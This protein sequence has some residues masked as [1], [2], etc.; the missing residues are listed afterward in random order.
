MQ[1]KSAERVSVYW[2]LMR[3][4]AQL[5]QDSKKSMSRIPRRTEEPTESFSSQPKVLK[6]TSVE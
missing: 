4:Q 5:V 3:V 1:R 2:L 6:I